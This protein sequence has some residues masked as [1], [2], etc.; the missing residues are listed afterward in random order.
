M[1]PFQD[2]IVVK[3]VSGA[4]IIAALKHSILNLPKLDGRF[5]HV[6]GLRYVYDSR[7]APEDRL[8]SVDGID[9]EKTYT[10]AT[11]AY[12]MNGGDGFSM[13][14][15]SDD[16][17]EDA[18]V[19][20]HD[21]GLP[22]SVLL[23]NFFWAVSTVNEAMSD[24]RMQNN[25]AM[26]KLRRRLSLDGFVGESEGE[27]EMRIA[28]IVERR[29]VDLAAEDSDEAA[30]EDTAKENANA[31]L[32]SEQQ[33]KPKKPK[34]KSPEKCNALPSFRDLKQRPR[35]IESMTAFISSVC[36]DD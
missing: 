32:S 15:R 25:G 27:K 21:N 34:L 35:T 23:R 11:R 2:P 30:E 16:D 28:P 20:G 4:T 33:P 17:D 22:I 18:M 5:A 13:F 19:V 9:A 12:W 7:E 26:Q 29:I 31:N 6:S 10:I 1:A 3:R 36:L 8:V 14:K 24:A